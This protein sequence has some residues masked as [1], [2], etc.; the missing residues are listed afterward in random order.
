MSGKSQMVQN[1]AHLL[2]KLSLQLLCVVM[3]SLSP[4]S[5]MVVPLI[6]ELPTLPL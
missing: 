1:Y 2:V 5:N 4:V 3:R 6:P